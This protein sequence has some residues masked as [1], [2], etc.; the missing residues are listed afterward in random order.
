LAPS[1]ELVY[2]CTEP[3]KPEH[4]IERDT[5]MVNIASFENEPFVYGNEFYTIAFLNPDMQEKHKYS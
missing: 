3:F 2:T 5:M 1:S 4:N